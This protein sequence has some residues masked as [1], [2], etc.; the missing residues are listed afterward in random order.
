M[1][2]ATPRDFFGLDLL[3][4]DL[5]YGDAP[6]GTA[7]TGTRPGGRDRSRDDTVKTSGRQPQGTAT[8]DPAA[9]FDAGTNFANYTDPSMFGGTFEGGPTGGGFGAD[10]APGGS[11]GMGATKEV[12]CH[13]RGRCWE[14][15]VSLGEC[16]EIPD[17]GNTKGDPCSRSGQECIQGCE[18]CVRVRDKGSDFSWGCRPIH[19][20][21]DGCTEAPD[22]EDD[23]PVVT[24]DCAENGCPGVAPPCPENPPEHYEYR[25][26]CGPC[27]GAEG[28]VPTFQWECHLYY[29]GPAK[30]VP[31]GGEGGA[32]G[33]S[34]VTVNTGSTNTMPK[35]LVRLREGISSYLQNRYA[36]ATPKYG[37]D[38]TLEM[39]PEY[40]QALDLLRDARG[41]FSGAT[42]GARDAYQG[43]LG[44]DL[45][46]PLMGRLQQFQDPMMRALA[47]PADPTARTNLQDLARTGGEQN[48]TGVMDAI[49]TRGMQDIEDFQASE[50]ERFGAMG[51]S[52]G[53][54]VSESLG[55]GTSR[56][57]AEMVRQQQLLAA[58]ASSRQ[59]QTRLGAA[60][61]LGGLDISEIGSL[62]SAMQTGAGI[63]GM[64][65]SA[66]VQ[67]AG[68]RQGGAQG[69]SGLAQFVA[70][71]DQASSAGLAGMGD[72][73]REMDAQN[74]NAQYSEWLRQQEPSPY[75][76]AALG[77]ATGFP[78]RPN[79]KPV[80]PEGG[81]GGLG[82]TLATGA[83]TALPFILSAFLGPGGAALGGA[84]A[85]RSGYGSF[86]DPWG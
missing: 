29:I 32:G 20:L 1:A 49:R 35:D 63:A 73:R 8:F 54:D 27:E 17:C 5:A 42:A 22:P 28:D 72:I 24:S 13:E 39:P 19:P 15:D 48:L 65:T 4:P 30:G 36:M 50:R 70:S 51:L 18:E 67:Q 23:P 66:A 10:S 2:S 56:G 57:I 37:G 21:P 83:M 75:L 85:G 25:A 80:I 52:A 86:F 77:Y 46:N 41:N 58:E 68:I 11:Y 61:T 14:W 60:G 33:S 69:L 74:M 84:A 43:M 44:T 26:E 64:P 71:L 47:G 31:R 7:Q 6:G 3:L 81:G 82:S 55:R 79:P 38:L 34:R 45:V 12:E 16:I 78:P 76:S 40:Q 53:S 9:I 59:A 62:I